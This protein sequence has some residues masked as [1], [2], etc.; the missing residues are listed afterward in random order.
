MN[1][2][3]ESKARRR[4]ALSLV[5]LVAVIATMVAGPP[6]PRLARSPRR[7]GLQRSRP[8]AMTAP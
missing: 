8:H 4:L 3:R 2:A 6:P 5:A 7:A 1:E